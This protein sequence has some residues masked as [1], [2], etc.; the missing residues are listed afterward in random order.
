MGRCPTLSDEA[1][2]RPRSPNDL[3]T[4]RGL[5]RVCGK[6]TRL[7]GARLGPPVGSSDRDH[8]SVAPSP[9]SSS[10]ARKASS[11]WRK[12]LL[13]ARSSD[14]LI[15]LGWAGNY[16][17]GTGRSE[18][19]QGLDDLS[20]SRMAPTSQGEGAVPAGGDRV[21]F[22]GLARLASELELPELPTP[23]LVVDLDV[24]ERNIERMA[25]YF[26][27]SRS[28]LRPHMKHHKCSEISRLQLKAGCAGITCATS[29]EIRAAVR[30]G[31]DDILLAN[32]LTDRKRLASVAD[33]ARD[34]KVTIASDSAHAAQLAS[35]AATDHHVH[36]GV[37]VEV[38]IGMHRSGVSTAD[39]AV[40]L[41]QY[42][43]SLPGL[44]FRGIMAYEGGLV[45]IEDRAARSAAVHAAFEPIGDLLEQLKRA[46]LDVEMVTG[47]A[48]STYDVAY[49]LPYLTDV[50]A[51]SYVFMDAAYA[52]LV[53]EFEVA[54]A[55]I[56]TVA[57]SR[58]GR[59][60]VLDVGSKRISTDWGIP[61]LAGFHARH[62]ANSEEH[63]RFMVEGPRMP[64]VGER[65]AVVPGHSSSTVSLYQHLVGCRNNRFER[66]LKVDGR[67]AIA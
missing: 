12:D 17:H 31:I 22:P 27:T 9:A 38:D 33:S 25:A 48:A 67:D 41:A 54:L 11:A 64:E 34:A 49:G 10:F 56:A 43:A 4:D 66:I 65:V 3:A 14:N 26:G 61:V 29:D 59:P 7:R 8:R 5:R 52:T 19:R 6:L 46:G 58:P 40:E 39:E 63:N 45:E 18:M 23:F 37:V 44:S 16:D 55:A 60:V 35:A 2:R 32:V 57:T 15:W 47:G 20:A 62:Y 24:M 53:P 1:A 30:G 51:G 28:R 36:L 21:P 42:I 13:I 50:Q